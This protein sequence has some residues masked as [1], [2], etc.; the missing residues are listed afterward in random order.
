M[1][2]KPYLKTN[3][4]V[5]ALI[6]E[7]SFLTSCV[8]TTQAPHA[9]AFIAKENDSSLT[10]VPSLS[11]KQ[12][13]FDKASYYYGL[14]FF[15]LKAQ[16]F[17]GAIDYFKKA[18]QYDPTSSFLNF[19]LGLIFNYLA[20]YE[21]DKSIR[22]GGFKRAEYY[23]EN[24]L[25]K[26]PNEIKIISLLADTYTSL[27][28]TDQAINLYKKI[29]KIE[30]NEDESRFHLAELLTRSSLFIES[31]D[32]LKMLSE[33]YSDQWEFNF[34]MGLNYFLMRKYDEAL[35]FLKKGFKE[36]QYNSK[37]VFYLGTLLTKKGKYKEALEVYKPICQISPKDSPFYKYKVE[38]LLILKKYDEAEKLLGEILD[39]VDDDYIW[40]YYLGLLK[41]D[42]EDFKEAIHYFQKARKLNQI[43]DRIIN[44]MS[45]IYFHLGKLDAS[46]NVIEKAIESNDKDAMLYLYLGD[47]YFRLKDYPNALKSYTNG[48]SLDSQNPN[49]LFQSAIVLNEQKKYALTEK[50]LKKV[51]SID[52]NHKYALNFISYFYAEH[53]IHL[54]EA[55]NY[56]KKALEIDPDNG[57]FIDTLGF[58]LYKQG[59]FK[60]ALKQFQSALEHLG[61]NDPII[62]EH[63]GNTFLELG[64]FQNAVKAWKQAIMVN[65]VKGKKSYISLD[66]ISKDLKQKIQNY[67]YKKNSIN[68]ICETSQKSK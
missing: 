19:N 53:N 46:I 11:T 34:Q 21:R 58:V 15:A 7:I 55:L 23:L 65:S 38:L 2:I 14:G 50:A 62:I 6:F 26:N 9:K 10:K 40:Y 56:I 52:N 59:K 31:I 41:E 33:K 8:S 30:P 49:F 20:Q 29:L 36:N 16:D 68:S 18:L 4:I 60:K 35:T 25:I 22:F 43:D 17:D 47:A 3:L 48:A 42:K 28:E 61:K 44:E 37:L 39:E 67:R 57:A 27:G 32:N 12:V 1:H 13:D 51:L 24:A 66:T 54:D 45:M 64:C 5:F 63:L